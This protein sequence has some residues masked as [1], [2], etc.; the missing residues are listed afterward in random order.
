MNHRLMSYKKNSQTL[1]TFIKESI[2]ISIK[3]ISNVRMNRYGEIRSS[4]WEPLSRLTL[5]RTRIF[6]A[7]HGLGRGAKRLSLPKI[8]HT[9]PRM[10]WN[11]TV[12]PYL[13]KKKKNMNHVTHTLSS[14]DISIFSS[15]SS[16]FCYIKKYRYRLH[17]GTSFLILLSFLESLKILQIT[18]L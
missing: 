7:A 2:V 13:K 16:K 4:Y 11:L 10:I 1:I 9:F 12:I 6:A 17:F 8:C 3:R 5:F 18:W 15:E 14:A